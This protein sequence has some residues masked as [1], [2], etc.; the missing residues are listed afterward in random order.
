[1]GIL[2]TFK[3]DGKVAVVTGAGRGLGQGI[4]VG[5]A[6]AGA[7][8]Y[9]VGSALDGDATMALVEKAGRRFLW[10]S[11]D[12]ISQAPMKR[13]KTTNH[14]NL[15]KKYKMFVLLVRF[16]VIFLIFIGVHSVCIT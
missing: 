3:L 4:A 16:V 2:D 12:L 9:G 13:N 1:M 5:L 7:D 11:A 6:Q 10:H 8:I 15:T 14:T